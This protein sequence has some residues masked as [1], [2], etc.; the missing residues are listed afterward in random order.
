MGTLWQDLRY[1][2]RLLAKSPGF[3]VVAVMTLALGIG[4]NTAIF[5]IVNAVLLRPFPY[6][7]PSRLVMLSEVEWKSGHTSS[8]SLANLA[9]WNNQSAAF[10]DVATSRFQ[11]FNLASRPG[12]SGEPEEF[13]GY[14]VSPSLFPALGVEAALGRTFLGSEGQPGRD[15]VVVISH[16]LWRRRFGGDAN[17]VGQTIELNGENCTVVGVMAPGFQYPPLTMVYTPELWAPL[18]PTEQQAHDR[19]ARFVTAVA[20]LKA[21]VTLEQ[22]Q[23]RLDGVAKRLGQQYPDTN[24]GRGVRITPLRESAGQSARRGLVLLLGAVGFVLLIAC[25]NVAN[26]LLARASAREKEFAIRQALGAERWRLARQ[27]LTESLLL[28]VLGG[29]LGVLAAWWGVGLVKASWIWFN[30]RGAQIAPDPRVLAFTAAVSLLTGLLAGLAPAL[31]AAGARAW[32]AGG[33]RIAAPR[34]RRGAVSRL[35]VVSE[36]ALA[37]V[38]LIA[39]GLMINGLWR[40]RQVNPGFRP[41]HVLTMRVL[42]PE[43]KY[44]TAARI[45]LFY[46]QLL[47][48]I[49]SLPG[50]QAAGTVSSLPLGRLEETVTFRLE[51]WPEPPRGEEP[52]VTFS[53]VGGDYFRA[54]GIPLVKGRYFDERDG[55]NT[56]PV[57]LINQAAARRYWPDADPIGKRVLVARGAWN[58]IVGVVGDVKQLDLDREVRPQMYLLYSQASGRMRADYGT[59]FI[60]LVLRT[61]SENPSSVAAAARSTVWSIDKDQPVADVRT[62][63][64]VVADAV[65]G[66]RFFLTL[67]SIF[68]VLALALAAAGIYGVMSYAVSR[69]TQEI[70]I[71]MA[72]GAQPGDVLRLVI[73]QG[74]VLV[75]AGVAIGLVAALAVTRVLASSLYGVSPTDPATFAAV[76]V[77]LALVALAASYIPAR[78][79]TKV[80]PM[81]ALRSE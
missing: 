48:R 50:V 18:V 70:G 61:A 29:G 32:A 46:Q 8:V 2:A 71:R 43:E 7:D 21:G 28:A 15:H 10:E 45:T 12:R 6:K 66:R 47:E 73:R 42:L 34:G 4:A 17:L 30:V 78:R 53:R 25:A 31:R 63:E 58:Q 57:T 11:F 14:R 19:A 77:L 72:L 23:A 41:E 24:K 62:M 76:S 20:R 40:L 75:L 51:G 26:L 80:D 68:A 64:Q 35:L 37:L 49:Q 74:M 33:L 9:D 3:T 56:T 54:M 39:A 81:A 22:A 1:S 65:A 13:L 67:L 38:L 55:E 52:A 59:R 5:S 36:V 27:S 44:R 60:M 16:G 79:A 69:R